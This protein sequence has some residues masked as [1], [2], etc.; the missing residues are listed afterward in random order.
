MDRFLRQ[1][2]LGSLQRALR[3][4]LLTVFCT[5]IPLLLPDRAIDASRLRD[6]R[7]F[8]ASALPPTDSTRIRGVVEN[9]R[10]ARLEGIAIQ[11]RPAF[12]RDDWTTVL[13]DE[14]GRFELFEPPGLYVL[15]A[16]A[17]GFADSDESVLKQA[18][19]D[20][21][22]RIQ[23]RRDAPQAGPSFD[24]SRAAI[25]VERV[26]CQYGALAAAERAMTSAFNAA[27]GGL[28]GTDRA[29]LR[30]AQQRWYEHYVA[31]CNALPGDEMR[32]CVLGYLARRTDQLRV[33]R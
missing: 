33:L 27:L 10:G 1:R 32:Q 23:L 17:N 14:S 31:T 5:I 21:T 19:R 8:A 20:S 25:P 29:N 11:I 12:N 3:C 26:I 9:A 28:L 18:L 15:Y 30:N 24:C 2:T 4:V 7:P 6:G 22:L 13:T 16:H